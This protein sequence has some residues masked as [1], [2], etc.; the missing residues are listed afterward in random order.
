MSRF[1]KFV[2]AVVILLTV[3]FLC[4]GAETAFHEF[5]GGTPPVVRIVG[6]YSDDGADYID[7]IAIDGATNA[8]IAL[9]H[10]EH[11]VHTAV[12]FSVTFSQACT[13]TN[14]QTVIAF[15]TPAS[16]LIHL[17][18]HASA[19]AVASFTICEVTSIDPDEGTAKA[20]VNRNRTGTPATSGIFDL[21]D[22]PNAGFVDTYDLTA[23]L[24]ANITE[25]E[26]YHENIG[27]A[28]NPQTFSGGLSRGESEFVLRASTEY[29]VIV[30]SDDDNNNVHHIILEFNEHGAIR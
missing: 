2:V 21:D 9:S 24:N 17:V 8:I 16:P 14:E 10:Q 5:F 3:T 19:T 6:R 30:N 29:A 20:L 13:N 15:A 23:A 12:A 11:S 27:A 4:F 1:Q 28:G 26:I 25:N 7:E 18:A 22:P